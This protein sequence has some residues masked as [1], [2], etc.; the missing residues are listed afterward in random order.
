MRSLGMPFDQI[1]TEQL[2]KRYYNWASPIDSSFPT[3]STVSVTKGGSLTFSIVTLLPATH[4]LD[5]SWLVDGQPVGSGPSLVL[6]SS[7]LAITDHS[8][9]AIAHDPTTMVRSDLSGILTESTAWTLRVLRSA[10]DI[11]A[12]G[13]ANVVDVQLSVNQVLGISPPTN[14]V[15]GDGK[16]SVA[17]VQAVVNAA[18]GLGCPY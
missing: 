17:D 5:V 16:V 7:S 11:N 9:Q 2:I 14:D 8:V 12:D 3:T 18:L 1:N 10:C 4:T 6:S 15:N 13:A